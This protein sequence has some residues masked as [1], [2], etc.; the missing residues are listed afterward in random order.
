MFLKQRIL[1][2]NDHG[3]QGHSAGEQ[4]IMRVDT[5]ASQQSQK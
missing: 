5:T 3:S 4:I 2:I 1:K